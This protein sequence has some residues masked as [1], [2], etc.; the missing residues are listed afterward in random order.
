MTATT[1]STSNTLPFCGLP[2]TPADAI[3]PEAVAAVIGGGHSLGTPHEGTEN[4]PFFLR[5][6]SR[7]YTWSAE[8]PSVLDLRAGASLLDGV[9]DLGDITFD[10]MSLTEALAAIEAVVRALP[11]HV[12]PCLIGGDHS[13][14]LPVVR[15][16]CARRD[17]PFRVVQFDHHLD[18]QIWDKG[19]DRSAAAREPIFNT[20]VMSHVADEIGPGGLVQI[21]IDPY[22]TVEAVAAPA[23]LD[24]LATVGRQIC[25]TSPELDDP[26]AIRDAVGRGVDVY[27]TVDVDVLD[28]SAMSAT[29]Y[30]ADAGLTVRE[31][32]RSIDAVLAGN[33]LIG[34]DLVEFAAPR[35]ARDPKTLADGGRAVT[36][37]LHLLG[38]LTRQSRQ[39]PAPNPGEHL[40]TPFPEA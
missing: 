38:W 17:R 15:A 11:P 4:G 6:L 35:T 40:I 9:V 25:L 30:P 28:R 3:A 33:R 37:M 39:A 23:V 10:G 16:L 2:S 8:T 34:F 14:T 7:A 13:V 1:P 12:A 27:L 5:T 26:E 18:L 29:G 22:A 21:G 24:Y 32:L 20:N 36:I 31:L 19:T